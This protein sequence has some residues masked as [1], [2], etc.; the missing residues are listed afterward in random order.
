MR[1]F[2]EDITAAG[3]D[4]AAKKKPQ[5]EA[6]PEALQVD[7]PVLEDGGAEASESENAGA[8]GIPDAE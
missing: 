8:G 2:G 1:I 7:A 6:T 3:R 5:G 4:A